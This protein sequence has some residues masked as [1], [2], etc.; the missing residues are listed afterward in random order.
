MRINSP[1]V[2]LTSFEE[3]SCS[4]W[5]CLAL[6]SSDLLI[7]LSVKVLQCMLSSQ[8]QLIK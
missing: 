7:R 6:R 3:D 4:T 8:Q 2:Q 5:T 1:T